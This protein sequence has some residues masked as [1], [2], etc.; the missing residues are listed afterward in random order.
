MRLPGMFLKGAV[1]AGALL[2]GEAAVR[3]SREARA[4]DW[5]WYISPD[6]VYC[7]GCC[8]PGLLCCVSPDRCRVSPN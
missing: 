5:N 6:V 8:T 3:P 7:E 2:L 4:D 1:L